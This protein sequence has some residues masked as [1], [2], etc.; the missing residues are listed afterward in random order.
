MARSKTDSVPGTAQFREALLELRAEFTP[1][2]HAMLKAHCRAPGR[3]LT[4]TQLAKA[5]RYPKP[6]TANLHYSKLGRLIGEHL[7]FTPP[8]RKKKDE[9]VWINVLATAAALEPLRNGAVQPPPP[10]VKSKLASRDAT[11]VAGTGKTAAGA[12]AEQSV[13]D[14]LS[15]EAGQPNFVWKMRRELAEAL[16]SLP[17]GIKPVTA[18]S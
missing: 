7:H 12:I 4:T 10:A 5:A 1:G 18:T 17:W 8:M 16:L 11:A 3:C 15:A 13:V 9:P 2:H 6:G 14:P